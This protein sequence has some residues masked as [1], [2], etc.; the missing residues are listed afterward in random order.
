MSSY[1]HYTQPSQPPLPPQPPV[2][3]A[4]V[5]YY[6]QSYVQQPQPVQYQY[7]QA[8]VYTLFS[9]PP[10]QSQL[11]FQSQYLNSQQIPTIEQQQRSFYAAQ[12]PASHF[13][14]QQLYPTQPHI[15][16]PPQ[17]H[18]QVPPPQILPQDNAAGNMSPVQAHST[19]KA[20]VSVEATDISMDIEEMI[21]CPIWFVFF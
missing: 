14:A 1:N 4:P 5:P 11:P 15:Q 19:S 10:N 18:P 16:V 21:K 3:Y 8:P 6:H 20:Q 9:Q 12:P 13:P 17:H 2:N 7:G